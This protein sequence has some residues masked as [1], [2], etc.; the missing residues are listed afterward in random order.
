MKVSRSPEK[1]GGAGKLIMISALVIAILVGGGLA[2]TLLQPGSD[3]AEAGSVQPAAGGTA[4]GTQPEVPAQQVGENGMPIPTVTF[5][6]V[7]DEG[8][9]EVNLSSEFGRQ[10]WFTNQ[11]DTTN[12]A[13]TMYVALYNQDQDTIVRTIQMD[14]YLKGQPVDDAQI[15]VH[16]PYGPKRLVRYSRE[17]GTIQVA[18]FYDQPYTHS[19]FTPKLRVALVN[20]EVSLSN[21]KGPTT[22]SCSWT[23]PG[24]PTVSS[25]SSSRPSPTS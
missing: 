13:T 20:Q 23:P 18:Q 19:I 1:R 12:R 9:V 11:V 2:F 25:S 4:T 15:T 21:P 5:G 24:S 7:L 8:F 10:V 14:G 22:F 17:H 16:Y 6:E 3:Q